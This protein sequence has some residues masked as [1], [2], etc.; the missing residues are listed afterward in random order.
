[1]RPSCDVTGSQRHREH[2]AF[3]SRPRFEAFKGLPCLRSLG[4]LL[5]GVMLCAGRVIAGGD[6][7]PDWQEGDQWTVR[8]TYTVPGR[9]ISKDTA[10]IN[11]DDPYAP[12]P[13]LQALIT[14]VVDY[15]YWV[16]SVETLAGKK[17]A[18]VRVL[19]PPDRPPHNV[20][21]WILCFDVDRMAVTEVR[22]VRRRWSGVVTNRTRNPHGPDS[23]LSSD[24]DDTI[25]HD[26]PRIP[27]NAIDETRVFRRSVLGERP[28]VQMT[29]FTQTNVTS[30]L[31]ISNRYDN[32]FDYRVTVIWEP[33]RKWW[34]RAWNQIGT[35]VIRR[36]ELLEDE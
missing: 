8:S 23:Y 13:R 22:S 6:Y 18:V 5:V 28:I 36:C 20:Y 3:V 26:F 30:S 33:G 14:N 17:T 25:I 2:V 34:Q 1:M 29:S 15:T 24:T 21:D 19:A 4:V 9:W 10:L 16:K 27:K 7:A 35:N 12:N 11:R 31:V 32:R